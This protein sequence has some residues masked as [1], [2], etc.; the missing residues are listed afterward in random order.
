MGE[1]VRIGVAASIL[2]VSIDTLRRWDEEGRVQ[3]RRTAGGHR[4]I[5]SNTLRDLVRERQTTSGVS[6]RNQ[7]DGTVVSVRR[8]GLMAQI[9]LACGPYR[10]VSLIS[11][12]AADELDLQPGDS[13][14]AL[15]KATSVEIR[16]A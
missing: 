1:E 12:E 16:R 9:D 15:V 14:A 3:F 8:D 7:L 10:V 4:V 13:A 6:T 11:R 5:D 2:G